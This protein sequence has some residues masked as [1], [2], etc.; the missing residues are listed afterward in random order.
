MAYLTDRFR[1][2]MD[3]KGRV[4]FPA[5]FRK[6]LP[7]EL[8]VIPSPAKDCL[9]VFEPVEYEKWIDSIFEAKGGFKADS[10]QHQKWLRAL[11]SRTADV[12]IDKAGRIGLKP[13]FRKLA[14]IEGEVELV[15]V[16]NHVEIWNAERWDEANS[17][18][19][20]DDLD[21]LM[22]G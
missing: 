6:V 9:W 22:V 16:K 15:G 18:D 8:K 13:E 11:S 3:E 5:S 17:F 2:K 7:S 1:H 20:F 4:S 19:A 10:M 21:G 14:D 12:E